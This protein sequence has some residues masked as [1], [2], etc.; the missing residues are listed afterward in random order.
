[1]EPGYK[2]TEFWLTA[3]GA[4]VAAVI[5]LLVAYKVLDEA[6][7]QLWAGLI[8]AVAGVVVPVVIGSM[9]KAYT[10]SRTDVKMAAIMA[11]DGATVREQG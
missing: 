11:S 10:A 4:I 1:M 5:P 7:G 6:Q 2:T 8:L 3:I 9:V